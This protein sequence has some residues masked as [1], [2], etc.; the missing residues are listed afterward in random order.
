[1]YSNLKTILD[2]A[3]RHHYAVLAAGAF[4]LETMR[5]LIAAAHEEQAPVIILVGQNMIKR[6]AHTKLIV[7][8]VKELAAQTNVPVALILDHG[9][10]WDMITETFRAGFSSM[11]IDASAY[12]ME[13]NIAR[14]KKVVELCH[15]QGVPVEGELG[16]VGVAASLD[17]CDESMYTKPEEVL[18]FLAATHVDSLAI[19]CGTAHGKYPEGFVPTLNF[20]VIRKVRALTNVP[21]ALHGT[22]GAGN[23]NIR[24]AVE[25]GINKVNVATEIFCGCRDFTKARLAQNPDCDYI[26]LCIE[27]EQRC[28]EICRHFIG[29]TGSAGKA[30]N[31]KPAHHFGKSVAS[32]LLDQG[33]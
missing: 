18:T 29:L 3:V 28:K 31:F 6:H 25:A 12:P 1:M 14:T 33:E 7:P 24:K 15:A 26:E 11:M 5:G 2:D 30:E 21:L 16:H 13:E 27:V 10:D 23:E 9:R 22:S 17:G 20:D 8:M 19:A 4:N 32:D